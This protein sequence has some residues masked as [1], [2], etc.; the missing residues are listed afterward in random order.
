MVS[1]VLMSF[2]NFMVVSLPF[3]SVAAIAPAKLVYLVS[4][5]SAT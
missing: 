3:F 2:S 5:I 1:S 4:P